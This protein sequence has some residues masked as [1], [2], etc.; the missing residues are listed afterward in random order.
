MLVDLR[1]IRD[2]RIP[3]LRQ[4]G[5]QLQLRFVDGHDQIILF[6]VI[7]HVQ[8]IVQL[9]VVSLDEGNRARHIDLNFFHRDLLCGYCNFYAGI[10]P[11]TY[12]FFFTAKRSALFFFNLS[13]AHRS[14]P[15]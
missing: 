1:F 4:V 12:A 11:Q 2:S 6:A 14:R 15:T 10:M 3:L 5:R 8:R 13:A 7:L 9:C